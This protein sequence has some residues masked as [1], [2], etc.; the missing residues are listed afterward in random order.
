LPVHSISVLTLTAFQTSSLDSHGSDTWFHSMAIWNYSSEMPVSKDVGNNYQVFFLSN[1]N[2]H[3]SFLRF[4]AIQSSITNTSPSCKSI[5]NVHLLLE[6]L[7]N[8]NLET[9]RY[10]LYLFWSTKLSETKNC[11]FQSDWCY[12][13]LTDPNFVSSEPEWSYLLFYPSSTKET[14]FPQIFQYFG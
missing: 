11:L 8:H 13:T 9:Q 10:F 5:T 1:S 2:N 3:S 7:S 4:W 6:N 12:W 14:H